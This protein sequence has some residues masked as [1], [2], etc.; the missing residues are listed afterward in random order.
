MVRHPPSLS[1]SLSIVFVFLFVGCVCACVCVGG[2][3]PRQFYIT[4]INLY[5]LLLLLLFYLVCPLNPR[6][7]YSFVLKKKKKKMQLVSVHIFQVKLD[8]E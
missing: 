8:K 5:F 7:A 6:F 1:L 3:M 2:L 4:L